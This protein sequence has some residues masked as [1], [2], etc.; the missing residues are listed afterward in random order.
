MGPSEGLTFNAAA[1]AEYDYD[2]EDEDERRFF[3]VTIKNRS[4]KLIR[5]DI[6]RV[7]DCGEVLIHP[8]VPQG[9]VAQDGGGRPVAV[10]VQADHHENL[11]A[12]GECK[13][14]DDAG[15]RLVD[16]KKK[17]VRVT[18]F[19]RQFD[20]PGEWWRTGRRVPP[21]A[22]SGVREAK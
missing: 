18:A 8:R 1:Q 13:K 21:L 6:G 2:D 20:H 15:R 3:A 5:A 10:Q 17:L 12:H 9:L 4:A 14:V 16:S 11:A 7:A 19:T 22:R